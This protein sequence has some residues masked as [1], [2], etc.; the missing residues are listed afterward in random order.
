MSESEAQTLTEVLDETVEKTEGEKVSLGEILDAIGRQSFGPLLLVISIIT[1]SPIGAI[2]GVPAVMAVLVLLISGQIL[3]GRTYPWLPGRLL[4]M[5]FSRD[6][7]TKTQEKGRKWT[8]RI[9][10]VIGP[11]LE[12]LASGPATYVVA[13][14]SIGLAATFIP[15]ELVPFA[16]MAPAGA[17]LFLSLGLTARDGVLTSLGFAG[18]AAA[19]WLMVAYWPF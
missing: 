6:K 9:D 17:L 11:R 15:L 16:V 5:E 4:R 18:T 14:I 10:K 19:V 12:F 8:K 7:L 13:L 2:P 1:I 3:T